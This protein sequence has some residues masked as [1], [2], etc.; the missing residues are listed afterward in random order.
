M[1]SDD[2]IESGLPDLTG[3]TLAQL[4]ELEGLPVP[5]AGG[6][7]KKETQCSRAEGVD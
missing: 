1:T 2:M 7:V 5:D 6:P 4:R 3:V